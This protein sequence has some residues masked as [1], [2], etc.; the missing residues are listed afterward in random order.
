[1]KHSVRTSKQGKWP[2]QQMIVMDHSD[3]LDP[4]WSLGKRRVL[5]SPHPLAESAAWWRNVHMHPHTNE[6]Q[7]HSG[8]FP[9]LWSAC[10]RHLRMWVICRSAWPAHLVPADCSC[11]RAIHPGWHQLGHLQGWNRGLSAEAWSRQTQQTSGLSS[12]CIACRIPGLRRQL[13]LN[14]ADQKRKSHK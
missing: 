4:T 5:N 8:H 11:H 2:E 6:Y 1:M 14:P 12:A 3:I 9:S 7:Y 13:V 10:M